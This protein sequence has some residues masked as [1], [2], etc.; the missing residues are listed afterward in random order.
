[1]SRLWRV[2]STI[3]ACRA[4]TI[5]GIE[6]GIEETGTTELGISGNTGTTYQ[7]NPS[8]EAIFGINRIKEQHDSVKLQNGEVMLKND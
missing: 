4:R 7:N 2:L 8:E 5:E 6:E 3:R 1:M